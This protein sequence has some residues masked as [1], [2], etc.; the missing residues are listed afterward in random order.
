M[1]WLCLFLRPH[2]GDLSVYQCYRNGSDFFQ[3]QNKTIWKRLSL[4]VQVVWNSWL[5]YYC[6][7]VQ[8]AVFYLYSGQA[9]VQYKKKDIVIREGMVNQGN[10]LWVPLE[11]YGD[12]GMNAKFSHLY[13]DAATTS[14][15]L[16]RYLYKRC[17]QRAAIMALSKHVIHYWPWSGFPYYYM[18]TSHRKARSI[19]HTGTRSAVLCLWVLWTYTSTQCTKWTSRSKNGILMSVFVFGACLPFCM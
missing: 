1:N 8:R 7:N 16:F 18:T 9:Q 2:Y 14:P 10:Y 11:T 15:L 17:V 19:H 13:Y 6:L 5:I 3:M 12:L 4:A